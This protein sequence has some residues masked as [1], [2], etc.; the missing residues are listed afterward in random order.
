MRYKN[1]LVVRQGG[2]LKFMKLFGWLI[3]GSK[4]FVRFYKF[5]E[6]NYDNLAYNEIPSIITIITIITNIKPSYFD[7]TRVLKKKENL[8]RNFLIGIKDLCVRFEDL[9]IENNFKLYRH[10]KTGVLV[11]G[12][13][14][15]LDQ[16]ITDH[17]VF[18][19]DYLIRMM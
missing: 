13:D 1:S 6:E 19:N 2:I 10:E 15:G 4:D 14:Y 5:I 16:Y 8:L 7:C 11:K 12:Y 18:V 3:V 17:T 9:I